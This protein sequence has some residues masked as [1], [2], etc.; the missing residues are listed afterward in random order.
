MRKSRSHLIYAGKMARIM[1]Y[2]P[3]KFASWLFGYVWMNT[4]VFQ[5]WHFAKNTNPA[6]KKSKVG[7]LWHLKFCQLCRHFWIISMHD[8]TL[9]CSRIIN[10]K[11]PR[12][13]ITCSATMSIVQLYGHVVDMAPTLSR[14][15]ASPGVCLKRCTRSRVERCHQWGEETTCCCLATAIF[16]Q[17]KVDR[18]VT[19]GVFHIYLLSPFW[20]FL[21]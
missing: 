6:S 1:I 8:G 7:P 19:C 17:K 15:I 4:R 2:G 20:S 3:D 16:I 10:K 11:S 9:K 14:N 18:S 13:Q 12:G 21:C 5:M